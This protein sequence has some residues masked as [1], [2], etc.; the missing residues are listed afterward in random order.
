MKYHIF[1]K[2]LM[3]SKCILKS[4][5]ISYLPQTL[6]PFLQSPINSDFHFQ[7]WLVNLSF[8]RMNPP[9]MLIIIKL[10]LCS[11]HPLFDLAKTIFFS[12][13][14][15]WLARLSFCLLFALHF[16]PFPLLRLT[17]WKIEMSAQVVYTKCDCPS[18]I[19]LPLFDFL[20][21]SPAPQKGKCTKMKIKF[22]SALP[23]AN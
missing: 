15:L 21:F 1:Y 12:D 7:Q 5:K 2:I 16:S 4:L 8:E 11:E 22:L 19:L 14:H 20:S 18:E 13:F 3:L 6:F 9:Q 10:N 23:L 17:L